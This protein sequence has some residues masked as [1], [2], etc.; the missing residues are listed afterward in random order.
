MA[1]R[2]ATPAANGP[3]NISCPSRAHPLPTRRAVFQSAG[4]R[5]LN[6]ARVGM[7]CD[8]DELLFSYQQTDAVEVN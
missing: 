3:A 1:V 8:L 5:R 7:W 2:I 4:N 6:G